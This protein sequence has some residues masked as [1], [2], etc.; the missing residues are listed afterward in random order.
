MAKI[1]L[2]SQ[3]N[4]LF[5]MVLPVRYK[6]VNTGKHLGFDHLVSLLQEARI[7]FFLANDYDELNRTEVGFMIA[8]LAVQYLSEAFIND[9]LL[10]EVGIADIREKGFDISYVVSNQR[11]KKTVARAKTGAVFFNKIHK[12]TAP[13]PPELLSRLQRK[14]T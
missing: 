9:A 7:A 8:D 6:D 13:I 4:V 5:S 12:Q 3:E 14:L 2:P 1:E 11:T 10:I